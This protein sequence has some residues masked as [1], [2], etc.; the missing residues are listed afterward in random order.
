MLQQGRDE[1]NL[2]LLVCDDIANLIS[3][4][5]LCKR[6]KNYQMLHSSGHMIPLSIDNFIM[7]AQQYLEYNN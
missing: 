5:D 7:I 3:C 2:P 1:R 4:T 6:T